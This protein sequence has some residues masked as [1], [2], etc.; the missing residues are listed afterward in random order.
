M[1][2][3]ADSIVMGGLS[4]VGVPPAIAAAG[5]AVVEAAALKATG[6][7]RKRNG[8]N[9]FLKRY[10]ANYRKANPKGRKTFG[11]LSKEA[12]RKW[13]REKR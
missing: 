5:P 13:R 6:R 3:L 10:V 4:A 12:S 11:A 1:R 8:W 9:A 2:G 7:K